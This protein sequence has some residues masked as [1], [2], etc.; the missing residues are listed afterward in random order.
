MRK[1]YPKRIVCLT[2]ET[3]E[4]IYMLQEQ[5]RIV[6]ISGF[7]VRPPKAIKEKPKV[8]LFT[9]ARIDDICDLKPDLV[10]GFSDI[11][12]DIAKELIERGISVLINNHRSINGIKKMIYQIGLLV[13]KKKQSI[14]II[15]L[16][17][18][19]INKI[20]KKA[21]AWDVK[22]KVYFEEWDSPI[23]SGIK[24]VSQ[25]IELA[26][27]I[28]IFQELGKEPLAKNRIIKN[29]SQ[30]ISRNP[31]IILV[32]WCGKKFKKEN[33]INRFGWNRITAI[34]NNHI[35]EIKSEIIL[36]PGPACLI[37]GLEIIHQIFNDWQ[38]SDI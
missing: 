26:G 4:I 24:W 25:T 32:S 11:Q 33:L 18:D 9:S 14:I 16:I 12:A 6:G 10:I 7:T 17:E 23:I 31:D 21:Q 29:E 28:D 8:S 30:I 19:K 38:L 15:K 3:T 35:Y 20:F 2:D 5:D 27:G 13:G 1:Y 36:Q 22:P 37:E 34:K